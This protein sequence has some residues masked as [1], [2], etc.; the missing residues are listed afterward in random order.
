MTLETW[1]DYQKGRG[2]RPGAEM[3]IT[4][5]NLYGDLPS[6]ETQ[7]EQ[8]QTDPL[9]DVVADFQAGRLNTPEAVTA[10][11]QKRW[12]VWGGKIGLN[13]V[14]PAFEG[15]GEGLNQHL[16]KRDRPIYLPEELAA[17]TTRHLLGQIWPEMQNYSV[18]KRND[19][20]NEA[21]HV[22]WRYTEAVTA[23]PFLGTTEE[24]LRNMIQRAGREGLTGN[25]YIIAS[26]DHKLLTGEY[27]DQGVTWSRLLLSR[28]DG[29]VF[30]TGFSPGGRL[31]VHW[32]LGPDSCYPSV[33]GRS[34]E[35]VKK[36]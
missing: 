21:Q 5:L 23:A 25:E 30:S 16:L 32:F 33:G 17:Q 36:A 27:F 19:V 20:I 26:Q 18:Q 4:L 8:V 2:N 13:I 12:Q 6:T 31:V 22:G 7:A 24:A 9:A 1:I 10:S 28:N 34:S 3:G 29:R 35:G 15:S 14:V 11:W